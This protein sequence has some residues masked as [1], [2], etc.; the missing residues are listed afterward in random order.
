[1]LLQ[2]LVTNRL[3]GHDFPVFD[4]NGLNMALDNLPAHLRSPG[5]PKVTVS[6][7]S[8]LNP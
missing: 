1:M 8:H 3:G 6:Y 4:R 2:K 5:W 7:R